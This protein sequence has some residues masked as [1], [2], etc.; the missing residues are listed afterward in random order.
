MHCFSSPH[1]AL[2]H[3]WRWSLNY[4]NIKLNIDLWAYGK[5]TNQSFS[6]VKESSNPC[7]DPGKIWTA[8]SFS[9]TLLPT[10]R[11]QVSLWSFTLCSLPTTS[12]STTD[13]KTDLAQERPTPPQHW[14]S[15]ALQTEHLESQ[16]PEAL[17]DRAGCSSLPPGIIITIQEWLLSLLL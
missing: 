7:A 9:Q 14:C 12:Y 10:F 6:K 13:P 16:Q 15:A 17:P 3:Q 8:V 4:L 11:K 2:S 5:S 1:T